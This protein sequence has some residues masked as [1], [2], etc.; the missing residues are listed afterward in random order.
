MAH[1]NQMNVQL[2]KYLIH[3]VVKVHIYTYKFWMGF[4]DPLIYHDEL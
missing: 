1:M 2:P 4:L 3:G